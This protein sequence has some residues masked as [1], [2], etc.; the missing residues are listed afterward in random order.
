MTFDPLF[1]LITS[2]AVV[3][4]GMAKTGLPGA[5]M[6]G[7][8]VMAFAFPENTRMSVGALLPVL[9]VAD[10]MAVW[11]YRYQANWKQLA[12]IIPYAA[13]GMVLGYIVLEW[14]IGTRLKPIIGGLILLLTGLDLCRRRFGWDYDRSASRF[15]GYDGRA[16]GVW[17]D[18]RQ[19]G[20][21]EHA[22]LP[23]GFEVKTAKICRNE[24]YVFC[25]TEFRQ[26]NPI[27]DD[28]HHYQRNALVGF[29]PRARH[30]GRRISGDL[31]VAT[32]VTKAIRCH[33]A[34]I[35]RDGRNFFD[36]KLDRTS[37]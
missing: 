31:A 35:D 24:R 14:A 21:S 32:L 18:G 33:H 13:I 6:L 8:A 36:C 34:H 37:M 11:H 15:R 4:I 19:R 27:R 29:V 25:R 16:I 20:R 28:R 26:G 2:S 10:V 9:L 30:G 17:I 7:V 5:G 22:P 23:Y 12:G 3:I 1:L